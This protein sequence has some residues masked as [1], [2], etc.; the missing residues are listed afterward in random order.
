MAPKGDPSTGCKSVPAVSKATAQVGRKRISS[1]AD[2][3]ASKRTR[4]SQ[5]LMGDSVQDEQLEVDEQ[6]E[7]DEDQGD[8]EGGEVDELT[9]GIAKQGSGSVKTK[10]AGGRGHG[11]HGGKAVGCGGKAGRRGGKVAATEAEP[12]EGIDVPGYYYFFFVPS[13]QL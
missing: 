11:G 12:S 7:K 9:T 4:R 5:R 2:K 6:E 1:T 13:F 10:S 3:T 8:D